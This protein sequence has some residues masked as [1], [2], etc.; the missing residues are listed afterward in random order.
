MTFV[1][2]KAIRSANKRLDTVHS[3]TY[4][5]ADVAAA[6]DAVGLDRQHHYVAQRSAPLGAASAEV[7]TA[8]F[9]S[10]APR[11]VAASV[12]ACWEQVQPVVVHDARVRGVENMLGKIVDAAGEHRDELIATAPQVRTT[13]SAI[14]GGQELSGKALYAAHVHALE[15]VRARRSDLDDIM[16]MWCDITL[17]RE[18]RGDVHWAAC[19]THGL[20]GLRAVVLDSATGKTFNPKSMRKS[21]GWLVEEWDAEVAACESAGLLVRVMDGDEAVG[22]ELT[23][24]GVELKEVVEQATDAGVAS[25]WEALDDNQVAQLQDAAKLWAKSV[26]ASQIMPMKLF[27]RGR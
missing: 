19:L 16:G 22:L 8:T 25:A 10:F 20:T 9:Y 3:A 18:F 24:A 26:S 14:I 21:R 11:Y 1:R 13:L 17:I 5:S 15:H 7:V 4:F 2:E 6:L 12:P 27:G 23:A